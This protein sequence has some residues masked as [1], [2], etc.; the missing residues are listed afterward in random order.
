MKLGIGSSWDDGKYRRKQ[1]WP[2][3]GEVV[4]SDFSNSITGRDL[5]FTVIILAQNKV[6]QDLLELAPG[7]FRDRDL[8]LIVNLVVA[9]VV[10]DEKSQVGKGSLTNVCLNRG[11]CGDVGE[12]Q[13]KGGIRSC[14]LELDFGLLPRALVWQLRVGQELYQLVLHDYRSRTW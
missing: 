3:V 4:D 2:L 5:D 12:R 9:P 6:E 1:G 10:F 7:L 8:R 14:A 13:G 11:V